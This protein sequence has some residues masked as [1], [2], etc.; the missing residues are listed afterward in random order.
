MAA[1]QVCLR[2]VS[3]VCKDPGRRGVDAEGA[4]GWSTVVVVATC[5]RR[6]GPDGQGASSRRSLPLRP[7]PGTGRT[8]APHFRSCRVAR[9]PRRVP[10]L[11]G[12][13][14]RP[15]IVSRHRAHRA[16]AGISAPRRRVRRWSATSTAPSTPSSTNPAT[17]TTAAATTTTVG[18]MTGDELVWLE[19]SDSCT[20]RPTRACPTRLGHDL[21][22]EAPWRPSCAAVAASWLGWEHP[23]SGSGRVQAGHAGLRPGRQGSQVLMP[24]PPASAPHLPAHLTNEPSTR[25]WTAALPPPARQPATSQRRGQ[26]LRDQGNHRMT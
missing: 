21:V 26:G 5:R 23:P 22:N 12:A 2:S 10:P 20:P 11:E 25:R 6:I 18:A 19:G 24:P 8:P 15:A 7:V 13:F 1:G 3:L 4:R 17:P 16:A 14:P 9:D